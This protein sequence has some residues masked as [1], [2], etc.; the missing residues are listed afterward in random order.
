MFGLRVEPRFTARLSK[1]PSEACV[2]SHA[3]NEAALKK[4]PQLSD[5]ETD[6][7]EG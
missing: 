1:V 6:P 2:L 3:N 5:P 7:E 4:R